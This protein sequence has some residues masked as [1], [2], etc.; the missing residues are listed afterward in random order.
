MAEFAEMSQEELE[1]AKEAADR[2]R[3]T[4]KGI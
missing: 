3:G 1:Q 4:D 2:L